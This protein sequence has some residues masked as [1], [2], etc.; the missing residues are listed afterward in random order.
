MHTRLQQGIGA[1]KGIEIDQIEIALIEIGL[2]QQHLGWQPAEPNTLPEGGQGSEIALQQRP[3]LPIG[4]IDPELGKQR[5]L[6]GASLQP[7]AQGADATASHEIEPT[8]GALRPALTQASGNQHREIAR[9][10][11]IRPKKPLS[12]LQDGSAF[13]IVRTILLQGFV[14]A[15]THQ[16]APKRD[17]L[18]AATP[19]DWGDGAEW[20]WQGFR[21]H[22]RV[23]GP[24]SGRP[25]LLLHGF[26]ASSDHWRHNAEPLA[27][28]GYRVYGLDLIGFGRSE[29]PGHQ[30]QRP[31]DNRLW[32]RQVSAFLEQVAQVPQRGTAVL[33][34]NSLGGLTAL[35]TAV[36]RPDL[37][38]AVAAAPLPDPALMQPIPLRQPRRWRR[39]RRPLVVLAMRLLPLELLL[40]VISRTAL[41]RIGLQGAYRR[42][43]RHDRDLQQLIAR[44]ARRATAARALRAM[45]IGMALRPRGATAP[46]LLERLSQTST[47]PPLLLLWGR[48]DRFVP[49]LIGERLQ[50]EH[51]WLELAVLENSGHCPHDE[52]PDAFHGMV[53]GWLDRNLECND[54][55]ETVRGA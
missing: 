8:L 28:A 36:F 6:I 19:A 49:V 31:L 38:A 16:I 33:V 32:A 47:A 3:T 43:I 37:V 25:L 2:T 44:P 21:S 14:E 30:R 41:L 12:Q 42:S 52:S 48:Q 26:G 7:P 11:G 40:P 1:T 20:H 34:G 18:Q 23:L 10:T 55:L 39:L 45:S 46:A 54:P 50:Q 29:Q 35:T 51:P 5:G 15:T 13:A 22:W 17:A 24:E 27:A 9:R 4:I 53:L